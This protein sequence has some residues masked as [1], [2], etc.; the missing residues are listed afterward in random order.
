MRLA[1]KPFSGEGRFG[2]SKTASSPNSGV[3]EKGEG[4]EDGD[5]ENPTLPSFYDQTSDGVSLDEVQ[6]V[7]FLT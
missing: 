4:A 3:L 2:V 6:R 5:H 1:Q 7:V